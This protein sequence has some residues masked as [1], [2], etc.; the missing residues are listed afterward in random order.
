MKITSSQMLLVCVLSLLAGFVWA[1]FFPAAPYGV[2]APA[3]L[4]L[5]TAYWTKRTIQKSEKYSG[6]YPVRTL[7][8]RQPP[9]YNGE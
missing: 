5:A 6:V 2:F 1:T 4:G 9:N 8:E 3:V 7:S